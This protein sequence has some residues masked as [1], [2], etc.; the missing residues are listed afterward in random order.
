MTAPEDM[1]MIEAVL[2]EIRQVNL[3]RRYDTHARAMYHR[4]VLCESA[5]DEPSELAV[6]NQPPSQALSRPLY[7][8]PV[9][10]QAACTEMVTP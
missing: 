5:S 1:I 10:Q 8:Y 4:A 6:L 9:W 7:P 2:N 3:T